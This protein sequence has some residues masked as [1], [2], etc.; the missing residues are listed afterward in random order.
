VT[1]LNSPGTI[2][3]DYRGE[4][5]VLLVNLGETS[6]GIER[7][8]RIAQLVIA[9]VARARLEETGTAAATRRGAGG[10]GSTGVKVTAAHKRR[11]AP[12]TRS[13]QKSKSK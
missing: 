8:A 9:R 10:F 6:F 12:R 11:S 2:D 3:C 1:V 4:L 7:G 5:K 13:R